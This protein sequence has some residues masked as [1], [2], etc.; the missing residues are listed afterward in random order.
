MST[1]I[2]RIMDEGLSRPELRAKI[3][4]LQKPSSFAAKAIAGLSLFLLGVSNDEIFRMIAEGRSFLDILDRDW[5]SEKWSE[6][7]PKFEVATLFIDSEDR[8]YQPSEV[9]PSNIENIEQTM[10]RVR[11]VLGKFA[12]TSERKS[13]KSDEVE[14][15]L[16]ALYELS[17][18]YEQ[19]TGE[20]L[21]EYKFGRLLPQ[22]S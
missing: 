9:V 17:Q 12:D 6:K 8:Y 18:K 13:V 16:N 3:D 1:S 5:K 7:A 19:R 4:Q 11:E 20:T 15:T 14:E 22:V 2:E 10:Q 21:A